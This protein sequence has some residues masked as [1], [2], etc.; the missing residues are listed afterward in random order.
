VKIPPSPLFDDGLQVERTELAWR[1]TSLALAVASL[2]SIR[3][4]PIVL[5]IWSITI[6]V[7]GL[8]VALAMAIN[9]HRRYLKQSVSL[10]KTR[11]R[12]SQGAIMHFTTALLLALL[13]ITGLLA[14]IALRFPA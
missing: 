8:V 3:V 9:S 11:D 10:T 5:G 13:G 6:G 2:G 14:V 4:L 12:L 1:R 7:I